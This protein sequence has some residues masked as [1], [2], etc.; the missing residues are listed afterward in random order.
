MNLWQLISEDV[1]LK[2]EWCYGDSSAR[3][4]VK[5]LASDGTAA[6]VLY[7]LMQWSTRRRLGPL[8]MVFNKLNAVCCQCIIGRRA[9][10]G[11]GFVLIHSQ[12]I[13]INTDVVGGDRIYLEHQVTIGAE[14]GRSPVLGND[15]FVGAG[16]K[17]IG[18][19]AVGDGARVGANA[20]VV[21]EVPAHTTVVGIPAKIVSRRGGA[22]SPETLPE[23]RPTA[24]SASW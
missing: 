6:M 23:D 5:T 19:I 4:V 16:A 10:F 12:G 13:V 1:R 24:E 21:H 22:G 20:V 14:R 3:G 7:R 2:A 18:S 15:I 8:A 9:N 11:R 17:V